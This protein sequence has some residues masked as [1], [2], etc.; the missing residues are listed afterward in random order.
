MDSTSNSTPSDPVIKCEGVYKIFGDGA[1]RMLQ[2]SGGH[3]DAQKFQDAVVL[4]ALTMRPLKSR[5]AKC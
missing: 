5:R 3:V 1:E 4:S 2:E